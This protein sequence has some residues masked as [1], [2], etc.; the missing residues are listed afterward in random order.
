MIYI[1]EIVVA[2]MGSEAGS[3]QLLSKIPNVIDRG[4]ASSSTYRTGQYIDRF[5]SH[6]GLNT[7]LYL[8]GSST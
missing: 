4:F 5:L 3:L 2:A 7:S 1:G 8:T 6:S